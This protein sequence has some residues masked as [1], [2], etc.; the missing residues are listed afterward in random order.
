[1]EAEGIGR[2]GDWNNPITSRLRKG[3]ESTDIGMETDVTWSPPLRCDALSKRKKK[4]PSAFAAQ[5]S[6]E[7]I[8]TPPPQGV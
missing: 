2:H 3:A 8:A 7:S 6:R 1:M 5:T 4:T